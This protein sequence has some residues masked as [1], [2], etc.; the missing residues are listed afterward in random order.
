ML[1]SKLGKYIILRLIQ[2]IPT[3]IIVITINFILI[4]L[5]PGDPTTIL[6]AR[7]ASEEYITKVRLLVQF[8]SPKTSP[9]ARK[10]RSNL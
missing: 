1:I 4:H 7:R 8:I 10:W 6:V 2:M 9:S 3:M 5:A